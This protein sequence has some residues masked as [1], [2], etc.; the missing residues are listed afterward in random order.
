MSRLCLVLVSAASKKQV[1]YCLNY[2]LL[3]LLLLLLAVSI[4]SYPDH[5]IPAILLPNIHESSL[6]VLLFSSCLS[7][8][9]Q[10][11]F[12]VALNYELNSFKS[13]FT[14]K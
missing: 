9:S 8:P 6:M 3:L 1:V 13:H 14:F 2:L 5:V 10:T 4:L 7:K 12:P 11:S